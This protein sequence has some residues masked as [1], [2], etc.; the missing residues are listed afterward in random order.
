M[1]DMATYTFNEFRRVLRK[2]GFTKI[3]SRKHETWHKVLPS[4]AVLRIRVSHRQ[5]K[6]IP[7]WLSHEML[8]Q[9]GIDER[10]FKELLE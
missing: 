1:S 9:A 5:G 3:R 2:L 4:G 7:H 10:Y 6:D 8:R